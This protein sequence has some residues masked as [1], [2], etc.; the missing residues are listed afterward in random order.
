MDYL[1]PDFSGFSFFVCIV[2]GCNEEDRALY[3]AHFCNYF[4]SRR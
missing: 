2:L 4:P 1:S 3:L